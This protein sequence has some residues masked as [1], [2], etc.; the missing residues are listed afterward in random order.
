MASF[1]KQALYIALL[2]G[3][4]ALGLFVYAK[5]RTTVTLERPTRGPAVEAVYATGTVE[6]VYWSKVCPWAPAASPPSSP[7]TVT[8]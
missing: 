5:T 3:A 8:R 1:L 6:P 4:V 2:A 7:A